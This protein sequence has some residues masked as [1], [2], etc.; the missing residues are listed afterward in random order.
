[1][2]FVPRMGFQN[3][4]KLPLQHP[5]TQCKFQ[6]LL[7]I[8]TI[9]FL[10][11]ARILFP[12]PRNEEIVSVKVNH[13]VFFNLIEIQNVSGSFF[14][15]KICCFYISSHRIYKFI[16]LCQDLF[17]SNRGLLISNLWIRNELKIIYS[18]TEYKNSK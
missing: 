17:N 2:K 8:C 7:P 15:A 14:S 6:P 9:F 16:V 5:N 18:D 4:G 10:G 11:S 12:W 3:I 13:K 1:M